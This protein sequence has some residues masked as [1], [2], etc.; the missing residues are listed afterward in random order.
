M[1]F[2]QNFSQTNYLLGFLVTFISIFFFKKFEFTPSNL[3]LCFLY[4]ILFLPSSTLF[5]FNA[6]TEEFYIKWLSIFFFIF[7]IFNFPL[8]LIFSN[9]NFKFNI[10]YIPRFLLYFVLL[11]IFV[12]Y[13][14]TF[15]SEI[16]FNL[17]S[18]AGEEIYAK[19]SEVSSTRSGL[20][21][22]N[23]LF[24]NIQT[25]ILPLLLAIAIIKKD[26]LFLLCVILLYIF[27]FLV[28]SYKS[29]IFAPFLIIVS[30]F[31]IFN[32]KDDRKFVISFAFYFLLFLILSFIVDLVLDFKPMNFILVRRMI[33]LPTL[34]SSYYFDFFELSGFTNFTDLPLM[35]YFTHNSFDYII[36]KIIGEYYYNR[37]DMYANANFVADAYSKFGVI[38]VLLFSLVLRLICLIMDTFSYNKS[39]FLLFSIYII[40]IISLTNASLTVSLFTHGMFIATLLSL[41]IIEENYL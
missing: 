40:P 22:F 37:T 25:I 21:I 17:L 11:S 41:L 27:I 12:I 34:L 26:S 35:H 23:Y 19:R 5:A 9:K 10:N 28:T 14:F 32:N 6:I 3:V 39:P 4:F 8:K 13:L 29:I 1:G 30:F 18:L 31:T 20:G 7:L 16:N 2:Y 38:S 36:P 33:F 24:S 15:G